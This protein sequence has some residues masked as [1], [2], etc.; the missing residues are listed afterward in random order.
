MAVQEWATVQ[1]IKDQLSLTTWTQLTNDVED[2]E[3]YTQE[4]IQA[5]TD[6]ARSYILERYETESVGW[7]A[8][9][10]PK[11][12]RGAVRDIAICDI[13]DRRVNPTAPSQGLT[14]WQRRC[15]RA[16]DW[17]DAIGEGDLSLDVELVAGAPG[18]TRAFIVGANREAA[19]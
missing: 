1:D 16:R 19:Y 13:T 7:T 11:R 14:T 9:N 3:E 8:S 4:R 10:V 2:P 17:L 6:E 15:Q 12:L 5:A 18:G